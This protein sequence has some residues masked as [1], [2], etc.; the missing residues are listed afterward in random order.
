MTAFLETNY[1]PELLGKGF[2]LFQTNPEF[3]NEFAMRWKLAKARAN[4]PPAYSVNVIMR[5]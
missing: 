1:D 5:L 2:F 4:N 3:E